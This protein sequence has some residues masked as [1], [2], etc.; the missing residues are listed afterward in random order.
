MIRRFAKSTNHF[1]ISHSPVR[2]PRRAFL[3]AGGDGLREGFDVDEETD[4]TLLLHAE[5]ELHV[6]SC[7]GN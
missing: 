1:F 3:L 2:F 7:V 4:V 6:N 5:D